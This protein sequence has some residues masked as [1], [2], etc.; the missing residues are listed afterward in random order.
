VGY[1][2]VLGRRSATARLTDPPK[3]SCVP[4]RRARMVRAL[5]P[6]SL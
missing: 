3:A 1:T 2:A 5:P 4:K 6:G